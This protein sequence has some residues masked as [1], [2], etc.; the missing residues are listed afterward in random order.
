VSLG[1]RIAIGG[2][3]I[4]LVLMLSF[5]P[6]IY[7]IHAQNS[8]QNQTTT[9]E[10][11]T[12]S[13]SGLIIFLIFVV[14]LAA[15]WWKLKHRGGKYRERRYFPE[16]IKKETLHDQN[17]KCAICKRSVGVWDYDHIDG[18]RSHNDS[19]NC[20]ALCPNCHAKKTRGL[21]KQQQKSHFLCWLA[22]GIIIFLIIITI[23]NYKAIIDIITNGQ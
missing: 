7:T 13:E 11:S 3:S 17:Y 4:F 16:S 21:L 18:N 14:V 20:Q 23:M 1:R 19:S 9:T 8:A 15:I 2:G 10:Q 22:V 5:A 6:F 12:D